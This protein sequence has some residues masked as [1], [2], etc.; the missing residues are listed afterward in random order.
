[1]LGGANPRRQSRMSSVSSTESKY[2]RNED[3]HF[4]CPTCG[5]VKEKQNTM[6][7]HM[8]KHEAELPH[9]CKHCKKGFLQ[10]QTLDLHIKSKHSGAAAKEFECTMPDC[11]FSAHTKGNCRTHFFRVHCS[12]EVAELL[13]RNKEEGTIECTVCERSFNSIGLFYYHCGDCIGSLPST[14]ERSDALRA[15]LEA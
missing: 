2:I 3:G 6:Y 12:D 14:D 5:I 1:M 9:K 10:K 8:K 11:E 15:L 4:V 7:Y 13:H